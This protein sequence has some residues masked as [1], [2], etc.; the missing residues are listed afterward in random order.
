MVFRHHQQGQKLI[1]NQFG[2]PEPLP[3]SHSISPQD[4]DMVILP[5]VSFDRFGGRLGMGGGFYD[6][7]FAFRKENSGIKPILLGV[8]H[9]CQESERLSLD[10]WDIPLDVIVTDRHIFKGTN[11]RES[12]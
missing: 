9:S 5:L 11:V 7:T 1:N 10:V 6:R 4:L 3:S 8:A 12:E 2:I